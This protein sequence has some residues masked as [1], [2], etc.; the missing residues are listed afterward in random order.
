MQR[1][2]SKKSRGINAS[3]KR[4]MQWLKE[5]AICSACGTPG[6]VINH[7][8]AGSS[9]KIKVDLVSVLIGHAFVI[10]LCKDCDD[11]VTSGSRRALTDQYGPQSEL[12]LRQEAG[13]PDPAPEDIRAGIAAWG[14]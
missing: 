4:R 1:P 2:V 11:L 14:A 3:E 12:W 10:S 7:H 13:N 5:R 9:A 6:P 8:C